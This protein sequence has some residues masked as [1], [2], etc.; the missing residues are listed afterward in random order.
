MQ[1]D[2]SIP[3]GHHRTDMQPALSSAGREARPALL[4]L[5]RGGTAEHRREA[6]SA[7][8]SARPATL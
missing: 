3:G 2:Q 4:L 8:P 7:Q 6:V 5:S 1:T